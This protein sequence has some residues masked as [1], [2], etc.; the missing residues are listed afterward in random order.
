MTELVATSNKNAKIEKGRKLIKCPACTSYVL[1]KNF[2]RHKKKCDI[3]FN[4]K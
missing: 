3:K 2:A 4:K 1:E